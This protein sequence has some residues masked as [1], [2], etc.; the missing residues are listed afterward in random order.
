MRDQQYTQPLLSRR[1]EQA[2]A[3]LDDVRTLGLDY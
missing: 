3:D 1:V 2:L